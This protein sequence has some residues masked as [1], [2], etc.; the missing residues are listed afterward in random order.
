MSEFRF[1]YPDNLGLHRLFTF[2]TE[3]VVV[4]LTDMQLSLETASTG[5]RL[6]LEFFPPLPQAVFA[7]LHQLLIEADHSHY[8]TVSG[9]WWGDT[10][11]LHELN[12]YPT[13]KPLQIV[14]LPYS[15]E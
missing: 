4:K 9:F 3:G 7:T 8:V 10:M 11:R 12:F 6:E 13:E 5:K 2:E 1:V 15:G 14:G